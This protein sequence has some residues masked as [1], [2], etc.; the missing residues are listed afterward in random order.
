MD[1]ERFRRLPLMGILRGGTPEVVAPL[2]ETVVAAGLETLEVAMNTPDAATV[3]ARVVE[4]AGDRLMV[5]AGTVVSTAR[6]DAALGAGAT[7]V[8]LPTLVD[9]VVRDCRARDIPV[10]PG[11]LTPQEIFTAWRAGATMVKVFPAKVFGPEYL[12][13]VKG[14]FGDVE[15]LAC[16]GVGPANLGAFFACGASAV[17]FGGSVF[18]EARLRARDFEPVGAAVRQLIAAYR[19]AM[20]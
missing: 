19:A 2:V 16:G 9:E 10:F 1:V 14:P 8:V 20:A 17:A 18:T 6:L 4:V 15:L 7:F 12:R 5:G 3:L 11:A 13:E